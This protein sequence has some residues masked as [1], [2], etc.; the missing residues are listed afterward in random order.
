LA[1]HHLAGIF[2]QH[3]QDLKRFLFQLDA[4]A[5]LA[6]FAQFERNFKC[7]KAR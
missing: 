7:A 1:F 6:N 5:V 2:D 3:F 4:H